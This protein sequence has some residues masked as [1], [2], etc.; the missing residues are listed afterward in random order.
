MRLPCFPR[1]TLPKSG[2]WGALQPSR[3]GAARR[4]HPPWNG[5]DHAHLSPRSVR[6]DAHGITGAA[7]AR[8]PVRNLLPPGRDGRV[9]RRAYEAPW[10]RVRRRAASRNAHGGS[11]FL[12]QRNMLAFV[13]HVP[14]AFQNVFDERES[15]LL[16]THT[17][18]IRCPLFRSHLHVPLSR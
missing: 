16:C 9:L 2:P 6:V 15:W 17:V 14:V 4:R 12:L 1:C 11:H 10:P 7:G 13:F 5:P 18:K 3:C 8:V